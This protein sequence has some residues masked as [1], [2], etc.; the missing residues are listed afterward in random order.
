M[1][2]YA[3]YDNPVNLRR[4]AYNSLR[5]QV[6]FMTKGLVDDEA[7]RLK[8]CSDRGFPCSEWKSGTI[9][10]DYRCLPFGVMA[11]ELLNR[12]QAI[13]NLEKWSESLRADAERYRY[14]RKKVGIDGAGLF[15]P[16]GN[17]MV[18]PDLTDA[19][20]DKAIDLEGV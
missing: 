18:N 6:G 20:I 15:L 14:L 16:L 5:V 1:S 8:V 13:F 4:V 11:D 19:E 2:S 17:S 12:S 3:F 10:G 9:Y 7:V